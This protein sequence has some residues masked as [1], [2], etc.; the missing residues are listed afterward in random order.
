MCTKLTG[1]YPSLVDSKRK[2]ECGRAHVRA[3]FISLFGW[4]ETIKSISL[5]AGELILF[6]SLFGWFETLILSGEIETHLSLYPSLVD[7]KPRQTQNFLLLFRCLYPSL[8]DSKRHNQSARVLN[9]SVYIPLWLIRNGAA[10]L[11]NVVEKREGLY[12]S[13]VDSKLALRCEERAWKI[14][15]YIPLWLIRNTASTRVGS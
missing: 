6:I 3:L 15:V 7:S 8:V 9:H 14:L 12:P 2:S 4:F 10:R 11:R 1:L 5:S 13:L